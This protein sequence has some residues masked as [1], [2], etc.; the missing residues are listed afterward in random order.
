MHLELSF[1]KTTLVVIA[2]ILLYF[3]SG[4]ICGFLFSCPSSVWFV[5][6]EHRACRTIGNTDLSHSGRAQ[7]ALKGH[8]ILGLGALGDRGVWF[9]LKE[10]KYVDGVRTMTCHQNHNTHTHTHTHTMVAIQA[11]SYQSNHQSITTVYVLKKYRGLLHLFLLCV[12]VCVCV[13]FLCLQVWS[14]KCEQEVEKNKA[15]TEALQ[16]LT[17]EHHDLQPSLCKSRRSSTLSTLTEDDFYDAVSGQQPLSRRDVKM[18]SG[19]FSS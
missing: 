2:I 7:V 18:S 11:P 1:L 13:G 14:L 16:T 19:S 5:R 15:L 10:T 12:C 17:T 6:E 3:I 4:S 9:Q 8:S